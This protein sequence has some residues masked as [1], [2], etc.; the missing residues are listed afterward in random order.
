MVRLLEQM[1]E[2]TTAGDPMSLLKWTGK[3]TRT[4]AQELTRRGH[5]RKRDDRVALSRGHEIFLAR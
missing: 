4:I 2:E 5:P 1:L 3:S